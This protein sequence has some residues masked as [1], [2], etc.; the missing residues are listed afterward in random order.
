[1][2]GKVFVVD[3]ELHTRKTIV[4][5]I[6]M[7]RL[8][9]E[10]AGEASNG[11][12]AVEQME[13]LKP[14]L[15]ITDIRMPVMDGFQLA[16][17]IHRRG[18][19]AQVVVLTAYR[20]FTYAQTA[21]RYGVKDFLLKPCSEDEVFRVLRQA[22]DRFV[23]EE[24]KKDEIRQHALRSMILKLPHDPQ[25]LSELEPRIINRYL[26][27]V[28]VETYFPE[29]KNYRENDLG[30]LQF[31]IRNILEEIMEAKSKSAYLLHLLAHDFAVFLHPDP[32]GDASA[33]T[34]EPLF[35]EFADV[36]AELLGIRVICKPYGIVK[37]LPELTR[38]PDLMNRIRAEDPFH[39][40]T[41]LFPPHNIRCTQ[42]RKLYGRLQEVFLDNRHRDNVYWMDKTRYSA[43][44]GTDLEIRLRARGIQELHLVGV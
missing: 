32:G 28:K 22:Y 3:D 7:S 19:D 35:T 1:M 8:K 6:E 44:A 39:P 20:D 14:N 25:R 38:L 5:M 16:R 24:Q 15:V 18:S 26:W 29:A 40:E 33:K 11:Q 36:A 43:F 31:S 27:L 10:V 13:S 37:T 23:F 41:R 42:G 9:W 30:L 12:Q 4:K 34:Y 2:I 17:E 21:L